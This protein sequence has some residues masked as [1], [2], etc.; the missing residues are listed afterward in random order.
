[1]FLALPGTEKRMVNQAGSL[2]SSCWM[3]W[4]KTQTV[5]S[6]P[7][8]A[9]LRAIVGLVTDYHNKANIAIRQ[10]IEIIWLPSAYTSFIYT[11]QISVQQH[12]V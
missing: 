4:G 7:K 11:I 12:Y 6:R 8:Q 2:L 1:M 10:F 9:Y 5:N 3:R